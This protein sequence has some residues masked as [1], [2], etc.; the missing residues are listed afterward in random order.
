MIARKLRIHG[1][2]Q[3]VWFRDWAVRT[4]RS[5]AIKGWVRNREDGTVEAL[6]IG[7]PEAIERFTAACHEGSP[8]SRVERVDIEEA[9]AERL[10]GFEL[11]A[12]V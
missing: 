6:A 12:T 3:G 10:D 4:A 11:R 5:L 1:T 9:E 2:V 7:E 8:K